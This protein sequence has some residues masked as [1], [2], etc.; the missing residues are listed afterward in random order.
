MAIIPIEQC[1]LITICCVTNA[2]RK[3]ISTSLARLTAAPPRAQ[4]ALFSIERRDADVK[5]FASRVYKPVRHQKKRQ[6]E[7]LDPNDVDG[8]TARNLRTV[9]TP[10]KLE[11]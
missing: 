6:E 11:L 9:S 10:E 8:S 4:C 3:E 5:S 1:K 7:A 2:A